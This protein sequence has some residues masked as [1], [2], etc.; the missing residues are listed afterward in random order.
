M[1]TKYMIEVTTGND[2][3][4]LRVRTS[5]HGF[6]V[7]GVVEVFVTDEGEVLANVF[8]AYL[9]DHVMGRKMELA[10]VVTFE[11]AM[12]KVHKAMLNFVATTGGYPEAAAALEKALG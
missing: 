10:R 12:E 4:E 3:K 6:A 2:G 8:N 7:Y 1:F 5:V 11:T 9:D